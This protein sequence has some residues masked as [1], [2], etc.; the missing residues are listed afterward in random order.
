MSLRFV[1]ACLAMVAL[2]YLRRAVC[3]QPPLIPRKVL[4]GNPAKEF[5]QISPDG[6]RLAYL[7]EGDNGTLQLFVETLGGSDAKQVTLDQRRQVEAYQWAAD[8]IHVLFQQDQNGDE[9]FH[10][11]S[12]D[13]KTSQ[14]R[15][16]TPFVG[17][18]TN[19]VLT[20]PDHPDEILV[21]LNLRSRQAFDVYRINL[22]S[23][24]VVLDTENPGSV[25]SWTPDADFV[26]R[27][28]TVFEPQTGETQVWIR[29]TDRSPWR[30]LMR[31]SF[32]QSRIPGQINGGSVIAGFSP[33]G[34]TLYVVSGLHGDKTRLVEVDLKSGAEV[35]TLVE[36]TCCDVM[37]DQTYS[38]LT[39]WHSLLMVNPVSHQAEGAAFE[40]TKYKWRFADDR[41]GSDFDVLQKDLGGFVRVVSRDY[42]DTKWI[43]A[44][45]VDDAPQKFWLYERRTKS[46]RFLFSDFPQLENY[47]LAKEEP[48]TVTSRDGL[49]LVDYLTIPL[50]MDR[51]NLPLVVFPHGGPWYRD[52]WGV[53]DVPGGTQFLANRGYAVLRVN[54]R[55]S[56]GF[57][58]AFLNASTHEWG[59]KMQDD[60]TDSVRWAIREGIA[61]PRKIAIMGFSGG[62]YAALRGLTTTPDLYACGVDVYGP[63][64]VKT[65]FASMNTWWHASKARWVRRVGDVEHNDDWNRRIS[66]LYDA[67]KIRVPVLVAQGAND[68]RVNIKQS[69]MMVGAIRKNHVSVTYVVYPDEG[70]G[71]YRPEN[72]LD[73]FGR[74][75]GF[76]Q[77]C[78][79][80]RAEPFSSI[81]GSSAQLH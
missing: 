9:I 60:I 78:L 3:E 71:F 25:L 10:V 67:D 26:V 21:N 77:K 47:K 74:A 46:K 34:K 39:D 54:Y 27:A 28:A 32:E 58:S 69:D 50:G 81:P 55:G 33:T 1:A 22:K 52:D 11:F 4:F 45:I 16:L 79:G 5:P 51:K 72:N 73:F 23:G 44:Q 41:V 80:G 38:T 40:Y 12:V 14:V 65:L 37:D 63:A 17:V 2:P 15:D 36:D 35:R 8:G 42:N 57:G 20:S 62:G 70:H 13:L 6:T 18:T 59:L 56:T 64:D 76:L 29:D 49:T 19:N 30:T 53:S 68:A 66:P 7:A 24:A 48:I 75:E 61:D 31:F 43:V